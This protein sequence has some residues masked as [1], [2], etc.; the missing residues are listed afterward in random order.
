MWP[1]KHLL[2]P[3]LAAASISSSPTQ[4]M[5]CCPCWSLMCFAVSSIFLF[6]CV[7]I[8][9]CWSLC[10][11]KVSAHL[12]AAGR[13]VLRGYRQH[14]SV[15]GQT[16]HPFGQASTMCPWPLSPFSPSAGPLRPHN[17]WCWFLEQELSALD[18]KACCMFSH[19]KA[20]Q[21]EIWGLSFHAHA[22]NFLWL[23]SDYFFLLHMVIASNVC[24]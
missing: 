7:L 22:L 17:G 4:F 3:T 14:G 15:G 16:R 24:L 1:W 12:T 20:L 10:R 5:F 23:A 19:L 9:S 2:F 8:F 13:Q 21:G 6:E 18:V 11:K